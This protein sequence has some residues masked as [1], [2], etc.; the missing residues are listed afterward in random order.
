[1]WLSCPDD[2]TLPSAF[3]VRPAC[4]TLYWVTGRAFLLQVLLL[5]VLAAILPKEEKSPLTVFCKST[6]Q[7]QMHVNAYFLHTDPT[8]TWKMRAPSM[9]PFEKLEE[10]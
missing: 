5:C 8:E 3:P 7:A 2:S 10:F 9:C 1:M 6:F 4:V